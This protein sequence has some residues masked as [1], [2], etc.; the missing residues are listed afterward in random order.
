MICKDHKGKEYASAIKMCKAYGVS[1]D[2]YYSRK[3]L[4]Y[5]LERCLT[6]KGAKTT[7]EV[8]G[9]SNYNEEKV[10]DYRGIEYDTVA[11]M[12][13]A[14]AISK[15]TYYS[16]ISQG[17]SLEQALTGVGIPKELK[18][19]CI[20]HLGVEYESENKM[21]EAWGVARNTY[22][23]RVHRGY[24]T[25]QSLTGVGVEKNTREEISKLS[26]DHLGN[27]YSSISE[28]C[29][30]YHINTRTFRYR[31]QN[32]YTLE[33][34][35]TGI[36]VKS[37]NKVPCIDDKGNEYESI[38]SMCRDSNVNPMTYRERR[39]RGLS[40][41]E[42]LFS[43]RIRHKKCKDHTGKEFDSI[44]EM[45]KYYKVHRSTY[46]ERIKRGWSI[47]DSLLGRNDTNR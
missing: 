23:N 37:V 47:R 33:Q 20:D 29:E 26:V 30:Q 22:R 15:S 16:R 46:V 34:S 14:Y 5:S 24:N 40:I 7:N 31:I 4:G 10:V 19:T 43:D 8:I 17:Y 3:K 41:K 35:L 36:G 6:G 32:G 45:C 25:E 9:Q 39:K 18:K 11:D 21:C 2:T 13:R 42:G 38:T 1:K 12:C 28:M 44:S 27:V